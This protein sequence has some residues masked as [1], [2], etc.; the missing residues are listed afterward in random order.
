MPLDLHRCERGRERSSAP[1]GN[2]GR[3]SQEARAPGWLRVR[4]WLSFGFVCVS[5]ACKTQEGVLIRVQ[6]VPPPPSPS[7]CL[8]APGSRTRTAL[9]LS[10]SAIRRWPAPWGARSAFPALGLGSQSRPANAFTLH[11]RRRAGGGGAAA[12]DICSRP[13]FRFESHIRAGLTLPKGIWMWAECTMLTM[14]IAAWNGIF[15]ARKSSSSAAASLGPGRHQAHRAGQAL[16]PGG[17]DARLRPG[18]TDLPS[19]LPAPRPWGCPPRHRPASPQGQSR[20]R[21]ASRPHPSQW[22]EPL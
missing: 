1:A 20:P 7:S 17:R 4:A 18:R 12:H 11:Q 10:D 14:L 21:P 13:G 3:T 16:C 2:P 6:P 15:A 8:W 22:A 19:T 9:R 5:K